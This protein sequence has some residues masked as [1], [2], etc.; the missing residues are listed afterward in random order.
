MSSKVVRLAF[1]KLAALVLADEFAVADHDL[2]ANRHRVGPAFD[3]HSFK[4]IV[5][6]RHLLHSWR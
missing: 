4:R 3:G 2:A 1:E 6:H 5:I